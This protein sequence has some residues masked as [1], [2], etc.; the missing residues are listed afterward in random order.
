MPIE[1]EA[2]FLLSS[3]REKGHVT[4]A[5]TRIKQ[6][7]CFMDYGDKCQDPSKCQP[8][9]RKPEGER[10]FDTLSH[11]TEKCVIAKQR[12]RNDLLYVYID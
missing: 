5:S 2:V 8:V 12:L 7:L 11:V 3:S 4:F 1:I 6:V 10:T 9:R